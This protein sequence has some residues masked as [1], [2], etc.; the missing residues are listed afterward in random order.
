MKGVVLPFRL[1][2]SHR[3][4]LQTYSFE[5]PKGHDGPRAISE[6]MKWVPIVL[7]FCA[8]FVGRRGRLY[9]VCGQSVCSP[10]GPFW[11]AAKTRTPP[12]YSPQK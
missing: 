5:T 10:E 8:M 3:A 4:P 9:D 12:V 1:V 2:F 11:E 7:C 6:I